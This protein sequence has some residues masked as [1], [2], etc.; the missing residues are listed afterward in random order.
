M[1]SKLNLD[2]KCEGHSRNQKLMTWK[3]NMPPQKNLSGGCL[4]NW[5]EA[6]ADADSSK[7]IW[8]SPPV[9]LG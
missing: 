1:L 7:T 3:K 9:G 5:C 2:L 6:D 4:S 8:Q